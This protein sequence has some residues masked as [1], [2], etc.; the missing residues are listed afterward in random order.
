MNFPKGG[1]RNEVRYILT[2][3]PSL[4]G[5]DDNLCRVFRR[6]PIGPITHCTLQPFYVP[7]GALDCGAAFPYTFA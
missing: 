1:K 2:R 3:K 7:R 4:H 5:R 6:A